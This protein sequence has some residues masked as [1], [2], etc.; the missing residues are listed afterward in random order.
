M[1][2]TF[3]M[4]GFHLGRNEKLKDL[5]NTYINNDTLVIRTWVCEN[6]TEYH[7]APYHPN[8]PTVL[9]L[10]LILYTRFKET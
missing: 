5:K 8:L 2:W 7:I 6:N 1:D 3:T 4:P 9:I 10:H